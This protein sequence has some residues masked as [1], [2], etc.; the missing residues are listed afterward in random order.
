MEYSVKFDAAFCFS[1]RNF[2]SKAIGDFRGMRYKSTF[3]TDCYRN[4][5]HPIELNRGYS[6][7]DASK[8]YLACCSTWK[9]KIKRSEIGK[10]ITSL[11]NTQTIER[12]RYY[13]STLINIVA[14]LSIHQLVFKR[15]TDAIE[16]EDKVENGLF[17]SL[18]NYPIENNQRL[19]ELS[20]E[21]QYT[22]VLIS[23]TNLLLL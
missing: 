21:M 9:E 20:F 7:D 13:F 5:K 2:Q 17:L 15:K 14:F 3:T 8:E 18:F 23:K 11:V 6:K 4:R 10:E 12:S 19:R 1:C 22:P 16:S